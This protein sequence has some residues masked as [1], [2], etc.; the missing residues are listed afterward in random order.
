MASQTER[1]AAWLKAEDNPITA[2]M[3]VHLELD[4]R[5]CVGCYR[6]PTRKGATCGSM[7]STRG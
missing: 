4:L 7:V 1:T 3:L 5:I 6:E 2:M